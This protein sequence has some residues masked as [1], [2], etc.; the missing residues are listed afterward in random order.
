MHG[1]TM[2]FITIIIFIVVSFIQN[3]L[4]SSFCVHGEHKFKCTVLRIYY[5]WERPSEINTGFT[6]ANVSQFGVID[7]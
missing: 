1:E 3:I 4:L 2:K 6:Y 7:D 5:S